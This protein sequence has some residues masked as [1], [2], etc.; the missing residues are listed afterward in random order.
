[1]QGARKL[2]S[3]A[4]ALEKSEREN[5]EKGNRR[6]ERKKKKKQRKGTMTCVP[7][8]PVY[9]H[10]CDGRIPPVIGF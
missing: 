1:M 2:T 7:D 4:A 6:K 10:F 9:V 8:S 3:P 5:E